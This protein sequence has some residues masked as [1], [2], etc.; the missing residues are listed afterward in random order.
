[1]RR[2]ELL[3]PNWLAYRCSVAPPSSMPSLPNAVLQDSRNAS[4]ICGFPS[5]HDSL[6]SLMSTCPLPSASWVG[7]DTRLCGPPTRPVENA[8]ELVMTLKDEPGGGV[9]AMARFSSG[10]AGSASSRWLTS[11]SVFELS[12]AYW[13]GLNDGAEAMARMAPVLGSMA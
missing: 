8:A 5:P 13:F 7:A 6:S 3:K 2:L 10:S 12:V 4:M 1:M 9:W 11:A